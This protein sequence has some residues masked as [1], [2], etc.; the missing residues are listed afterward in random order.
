MKKQ[1]YDKFST[2]QKSYICSY[3]SAQEENMKLQVRKSANFVLV[4]LQAT[5]WFLTFSNIEPYKIK[6]Y[7]YLYSIHIF[8]K[9]FSSPQNCTI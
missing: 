9:Q 5:V 2:Q 4:K 1:N 3:V 8:P 7:I 6:C